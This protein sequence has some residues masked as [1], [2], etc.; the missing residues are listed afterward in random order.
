M[1]VEAEVILRVSESEFAWV[2]DIFLTACA[3]DNLG[4]QEEAFAQRF[5]E[6]VGYDMDDEEE[7]EETTVH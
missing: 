7:E 2:I 5:L 6:S 1:K 4:T 3:S